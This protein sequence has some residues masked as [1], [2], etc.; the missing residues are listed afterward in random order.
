MPLGHFGHLGQF[1]FTS[2][3]IFFELEAGFFFVSIF[4]NV[5]FV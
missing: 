1:V 5:S 3:C 2:A 4:F